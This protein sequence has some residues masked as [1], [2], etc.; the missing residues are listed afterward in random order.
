MNI[1]KTE[2]KNCPFCGSKKVHAG[3]L[4]GLCLSYSVRCKKCST[5]GPVCSIM[6]K[7]RSESCATDDLR[8]SAL[9]TSIRKWNKR[10]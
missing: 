6:E 4:D 1:L 2:L 5:M 9:N 3:P 10:K 7:I 8:V